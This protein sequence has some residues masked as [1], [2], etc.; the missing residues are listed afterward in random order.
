MLGRARH[1]GGDVVP[2]ARR[3]AVGQ[4]LDALFHGVDAGLGQL[5]DVEALLGSELHLDALLDEVADH[6]FQSLDRRLLQGLLQRL[7][8]LVAQL[9]QDPSDDEPGR[10][11][12]TQ[13]ADLRQAEAERRR[14]LGGDD[15][16]RQH[17]ELRDHRDLGDLGRDRG[18]LQGEGHQFGG[19]LGFVQVAATAVEPAPHLDEAVDRLARVVAGD[20]LRR[21]A[22]ALADPVDLLTELAPYLRGFPQLVLVG[23]RPVVAQDLQDPFELARQHDGHAKTSPVR[24]ESIQLAR[25]A[26]APTRASARGRC[27]HGVRDAAG[28]S[29]RSVR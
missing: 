3:E 6:G 27:T 16:D 17:D 26:L 7:D 4:V 8:Q 15:L 11:G 22:A 20:T 12:G 19:L 21:A 13:R 14:G 9:R 5:A 2:Q 29:G 24:E 28:P 23:V 18:G 10:L 1:A 25:P